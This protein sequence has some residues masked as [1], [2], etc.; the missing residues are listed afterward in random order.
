[1]PYRAGSWVGVHDTSDDMRI[2]YASSNLYDIVNIHA[3]DCIGTPATEFITGE[4]LETYVRITTSDGSAIVIRTISFICS[5][6]A[7]VIGSSDPSGLF[8]RMMQR[9]HI[10][11]FRYVTKDENRMETLT[12]IN[13]AISEAPDSGNSTAAAPQERLHGSTQEHQ[14]VLIQACI[15]LDNLE[16][17][18]S[19]TPHGPTITFLTNSME[20]IIDVDA[21][22][23]QGTPF[24]SLVAVDDISK[25]GEFLQGLLRHPF[26][27]PAEGQLP[28]CITVEMMGAGSETGA[29][30][31]CQPAVGLHL[32][33]MNC[34]LDEDAGY[35]TLEELVSSEAETSECDSAW[36]GIRPE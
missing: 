14:H 25:A 35:M 22:D 26:G 6:I 27:A 15:I 8:E 13:Q 9:D 2:L 17:V 12:Q 28:A 30:L 31:L 10:K 7:F 5:S 18:D 32:Q 29:I 36:R 4:S 19:R 21:T 20:Q 11:R 34:G 23:L 3:S 33:R 1:M 24:L 16:R